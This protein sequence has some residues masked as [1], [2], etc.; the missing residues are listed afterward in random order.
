MSSSVCARA[1]GALGRGAPPR[2]A[3]LRGLISGKLWLLAKKHQHGYVASPKCEFGC[4]ALALRSPV[5][6]V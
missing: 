1:S 3:D 4:D 5:V 2:Q 6:W